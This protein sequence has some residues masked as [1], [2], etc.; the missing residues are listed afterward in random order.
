LDAFTTLGAWRP[1]EHTRRA[2]RADGV[3]VL[4]PR[5]TRDPASPLTARELQIAT[6]VA[7]G[8]TNPEIAARLVLSV[9][10]VTSHL[11]H[12]YGRLEIGS[13]TALARWMTDRDR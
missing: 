1:A 12:I 3:R 7:E 4:A 2:L 13:R 9:R 5:P 8:L 6:L 10:T 11:E